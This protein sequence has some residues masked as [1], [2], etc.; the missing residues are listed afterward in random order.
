MIDDEQGKVWVP[1]CFRF[2]WHFPIMIYQVS[3]Q[4]IYLIYK[5]S[6]FNIDT[7]FLVGKERLK[8]LIGTNFRRHLISQK[9]RSAY[10]GGLYFRDLGAKLFSSGINFREIISLIL[11]L[12]YTSYCLK[13]SIYNK[14]KL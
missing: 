12:F 7:C 8:Y 9:K 2:P 1:T 6:I 3:V 5:Y 14:T 4:L 13:S 10:L 11:L